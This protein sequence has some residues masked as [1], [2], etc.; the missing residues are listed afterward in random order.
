MDEWVD[1]KWLNSGNV[2]FLASCCASSLHSD[3][4]INESRKGS[5]I[6]GVVPDVASS[7]HLE[8]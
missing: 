4:P 2:I 1:I 5:E 6:L 7:R 8:V 3:T